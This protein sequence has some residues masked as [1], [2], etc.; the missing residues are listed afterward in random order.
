MELKTPPGVYDIVPIDEAELWKSSF[1][2]EWVESTIRQIAKE[3]ALQEIRTPIFEKNELFSRIVGETSDIVS[4]EMYTFTDRG[5]RDLTLRPEGTA[6]VIRAFI[7]HKMGAKPG[8]HRLYYIAPMFRYDRP[9]AGR[10]RQHHQ[11]GVEIIGSDAAETDA[12]L[13]DIAYSL[14][15]KLGIKDLSIAINSL[16]NKEA[17]EAYKIALVAYFQSHE[18]ALSEDSKTRL[19]KNPLR[20]LDSKDPQD[21]ALVINAPSILEFLD[22]ESK[23]HLETTLSC[24]KS[25]KIPYQV[26]PLLVRGLDYYNKTVFEIVSGDLGAQN[27]I[28]GGG[29]YDGLLKELKG[30]D[31]PSCGFGSG[32]ERILQTLIA[33]KAALPRPAPLNLYLIPLTQEAKERCFMLQKTLREEKFSVISDF[34]GKK[35]NKSMNLANQAQAEYVGVIGEDELISSSVNIKNMLLGTTTKVPFDQLHQFLKTGHSHV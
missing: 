13:I 29:R 28:G 27:S 32:I 25:L 34:S 9:Q 4:K 26:N 12:E 24:L 1:L 21:R 22:I 35:L 30:P 31:L 19:L 10:Y 16:G 2:W 20:I 11:V 14:Y 3:Y 18:H 15:T 6:P 8:V 17:R 23:N 33:Q 5:G 7:E